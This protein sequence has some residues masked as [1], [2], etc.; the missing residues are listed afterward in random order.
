MPKV[1]FAADVKPL[2]RDIDISHMKRFGVKLDD[3]TYMS[4][5][6]NASSVLANLSPP[7]SNV[8]SVT[9]CGLT[10]STIARYTSYCSSSPGCVVRSM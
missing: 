4:A 3:Y 5:P 8:R 10:A 6:D 9:G 2:F 7:M 1:S